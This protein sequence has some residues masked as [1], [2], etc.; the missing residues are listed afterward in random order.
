MESTPGA[1]N[2]NVKHDVS[3]FVSTAPTFS[4]E[5]QQL[6]SELTPAT[7]FT[8]LQNVL[9]NFLDPRCNSL[10][11]RGTV[12]ECIQLFKPVVILWGIFQLVL[13]VS[14]IL[15]NTN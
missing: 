14:I 6:S 12:E 8:P 10:F 11:K 3:A 15:R 13:C 9:K 7:P 2:P 5:A 1:E 4:D